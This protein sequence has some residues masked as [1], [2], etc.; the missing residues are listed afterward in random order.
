MQFRKLL[1]LF[2]MTQCLNP[3]VLVEGCLTPQVHS[4]PMQ[5]MK[6]QQDSKVFLHME[7]TQELFME[8]LSLETGQGF[9]KGTQLIL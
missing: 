6:I 9:K 7:K 8:L 3:A 4:L 1:L 5:F 2:D